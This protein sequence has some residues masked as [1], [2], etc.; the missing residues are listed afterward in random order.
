MKKTIR[1]VVFT[2]Q[3]YFAVPEFI[4]LNSTYY[5]IMSIPNIQEL[6]Q[7]AFNHSSGIDFNEPLQ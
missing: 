6:Q 1:F 5:F 7:I 4:R 2:T 3:S